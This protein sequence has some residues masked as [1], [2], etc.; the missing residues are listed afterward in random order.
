MSGWGGPWGTM[1]W[2][3]RLGDTGVITQEQASYRL[4]L[5]NRSASGLGTPI[6]SDVLAAGVP[7]DN[8]A[9][10]RWGRTLNA[11]GTLEFSLPLDA[12][13]PEDFAPGQRELHLY[14]ED[15]SHAGE[16]LVW[17]G[18]LWVADVRTPWVRFLGVGFYEALRHREMSDDFY[19]F[20]ANANAEQRAIAWALIA[21]TQGQPG[22]GLGITR[23]STAGSG[24]L[25]TVDACAEERR[26]IADMIEDIAA[27]D[28]GFDFE[29]GP[30]KVWRTWIPQRGTDRS[31]TVTL[32]ATDTIVD[33]SYTIDATQVENDVA[34]IGKKGDC[35]PIYYVR[36]TDTD[37]R[38]TFGLMQG[39]ITRNDI[40]QDDDLIAA[41]ARERLALVKD[42]RKQPNVRIFQGL[43]GPSP[44][45]GEFDLGDVITV[46][47]SWG[48]ATFTDP[49]RVGS[50][51]VAFDR[52]GNEWLELT[53]DAVP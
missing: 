19:R 39:T 4:V 34:G 49:F 50:Y 15:S 33:M 23:G 5:A 22:G 21:Y 41:L 53:L 18:H 16:A 45:T 47:A 2:G 38:D 42:A 28:D 48:Y 9:A 7:F 11:A 31:A 27:A 36:E 32:D 35:E 44:L 10:G 8:Q 46:A 51:G 20:A 52:L 40:R 29:V 12:C 17:G 26:V 24:T 43:G 6:I 14:R 13:S 30:D 1:P 37:S 25:R 3:D